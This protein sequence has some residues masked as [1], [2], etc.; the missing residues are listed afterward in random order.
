ME[1]LQY[2]FSENAGKRLFAFFLISFFLLNVS[3]KW[4]LAQSYVPDLGG[5][6]RNVI[7][8]IQRIMAGQELYTNPENLPFS[9]VQYM[10][11]YY[12]VLAALGK[13]FS[14]Q[15]ADAH[16]VY[17]LARIFNL[18]LSLGFSSIVF[19]TSYWRFKV[20]VFLAG[21]FAILSFLISD[22]FT[23]SGRPDSLKAFFMVLQVLILCKS[24]GLK[25]RYKMAI[26]FLLSFCCLL[27]KQ[28][29]VVAFGI[30]PL[31][32]LFGAEWK[33][34]GIYVF[35]AVLV[36]SSGLMF[37]QWNYGDYF[38]ANTV[39]GLKN[40]ISFSWFMSVFRGFFG[41]YLILFA[42]ALMLA[43]EFA[44]EKNRA[45]RILAAAVFVVFFPSLLASLKFGSG[46]NYFQESLL[47]SCILLPIGISAFS[48]PAFFRFSTSKWIFPSLAFL[49]FFGLSGLNWFSGVFL[50]QEAALKTTYENDVAFASTL[51]QE[52][53]KHKIM[54]LTDRQWED[55]LTTIFFD[56]IVNPNRDVSA[57]VFE[58]KKGDALKGLRNHVSTNPN[59]ILLTRFGQRPSFA[60]Q[61]FSAFHVSR[62]F[63]GYQIWTK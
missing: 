18:M 57:Q 63:G 56:C 35:G 54:L 16:G 53:P 45:L 55:N 61:D 4:V 5:F 32:F 40:G 19:F 20:P 31:A 12:E 51:K 59:L 46:V 9:F 3:W 8:G 33:N 1:R 11:L 48:G 17:R 14:V 50:N 10:P 13:L 41:L 7:W 60:G 34:L 22:T 49:L 28:D 27:C 52:F 38:F 15:P 6:E 24:N 47:I 62:D 21:T 30:L 42:P 26:A 43:F 2:F 25:L 29:G 36:L 39:G 44:H 23:I 58:G 37:L